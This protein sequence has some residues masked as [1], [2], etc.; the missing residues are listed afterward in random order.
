MVTAQHRLL[1]EGLGVDHLR[2]VL[3]TSMGGMHAW[4]WAEKYPDFMDGIVPL[5]AVPTQIAGRNRVLRKMILDDIRDDP[6]WKNGDYAEQPPGLLP[7]VQILLIMTSSPLQWQKAAPTRDDADRFLADQ[8]RSRLAGAD[9]NNFVY[10]FDASRE[11]D[12]SPGLE[13]IETPRPRD[14]FG[15]RSDQPA[16]ARPDGEAHA[17]RTARNVR[18]AA[19]HSGDPRPRHALL[20]RHLAGASA[21]VSRQPAPSGRL[22][23][24]LVR[25]TGRPGAAK[26]GG[27]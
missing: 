9:A 14:Q 23:G 15:G 21:G 7:A 22:N 19:H 25:A 10:A 4:V 13:K 6:A 27:P 16:G 5:A 20:P 2:L 17:A 24:T 12:P 11:Y 1:T 3:G 18:P 26:L 8:L